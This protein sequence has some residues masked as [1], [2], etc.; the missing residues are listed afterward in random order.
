MNKK[1]FK[2]LK[3]GSLIV[4]FMHHSPLSITTGRFVKYSRGAIEVTQGSRTIWIDCGVVAMR[5]KESEGDVP[6]GYNAALATNPTKELEDN[7]NRWKSFTPKAAGSTV[8]FNAGQ[9]NE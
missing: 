6:P 7:M 5:Y 2:Q 9:K 3:K 8:G 4:L 1:I